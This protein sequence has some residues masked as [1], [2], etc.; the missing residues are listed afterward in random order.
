MR[1][2][3]AA[4]AALWI[5]VSAQGAAAQVN[6]ARAEQTCI[7]AA[8]E[9]FMFH[10][11][12]L[13]QKPL[14]DSR[15]RVTG[16][17]LEMEVRFLGKKTVVFC[18]FDAAK[19][20]AVI[21]VSRPSSGAPG[22]K[23]VPAADVVRACNRAAQ[24]QRLMVGDVVSQST[25]KNRQGQPIGRSVVMNVWQAGRPAQLKCDFDYASKTTALELSRPKPR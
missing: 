21:E 24:G 9:R 17:V 6:I 7:S 16:S 14:R 23:P 13:S 3:I 12:T 5:A 8:L 22:A 25:I 20:A 1:G 4:G 18:I 10:R 19:A 11:Q 15:G 2:W